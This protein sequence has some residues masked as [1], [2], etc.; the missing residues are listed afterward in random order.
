MSLLCLA[1]SF[2]Q[3]GP[4]FLFNKIN[5]TG[6]SYS[7]FFTNL[8]WNGNMP[9]Y[10]DP[11]N[12]PSV[13]R[14]TDTYDTLCLLSNLNLSRGCAP[15][16]THECISNRALKASSV[17][18]LSSPDKTLALLTYIIADDTGRSLLFTSLKKTEIICF[19]RLSFHCLWAFS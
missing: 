4:V 16:E 14:I 1:F 19:D 6:Q 5:I 15:T 7:Q 17:L 11:H 8:L 13:F 9:F 3:V 10:R 12:S 18:C 2:H